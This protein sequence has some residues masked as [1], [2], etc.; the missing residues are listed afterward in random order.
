MATIHLQSGKNTIKCNSK[1][2]VQ[3]VP[4]RIHADCDAKV[5]EYFDDYVKTEENNGS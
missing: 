1:A 2:K 3:S 4:F 5:K